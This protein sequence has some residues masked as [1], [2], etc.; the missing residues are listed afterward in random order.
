MSRRRPGQPSRARSKRHQ[1]MASALRFG[2][3]AKLLGAGGACNPG[4]AQPSFI[5]L[6]AHIHWHQRN[7]SIE[8]NHEN[9][10]RSSSEMK[11]QAQW[12]VTPAERG[13]LATTNAGPSHRATGSALAQN[14]L[15][16]PAFKKMRAGKR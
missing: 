6:R 5:V 7:T 2:Q 3:A 16:A 11:K 12:P 1:V 14:R 9:E 8:D 15:H 13:L 10:R 4:R